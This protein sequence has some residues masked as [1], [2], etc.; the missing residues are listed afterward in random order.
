MASPTL[1]SLVE[2]LRQAVVDH[3][4][5]TEALSPAE[6]GDWLGH[7]L[8]VEDVILSPETRCSACFFCLTA[9]VAPFDTAETPKLA[10]QGMHC[11]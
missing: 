6:P 4:E 7:L 9:D 11:A 8:F 5:N 3:P 1:L 2:A 10:S